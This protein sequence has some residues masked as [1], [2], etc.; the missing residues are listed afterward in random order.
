MSKKYFLWLA[1]FQAW[2]ATFGSLFFSEVLKF[3]PCTLCWYQRICMYPLTVI[4][5]VGLIR[6]NQEIYLYVLPLSLIGWIIS[7][8]HN[9]LFYHFIGQ[10]AFYCTIAGLCEER[11]LNW[12]G[13]IDIPLLSLTAFTIINLCLI[14]HWSWQR[15]RKN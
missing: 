12:L 14:F 15:N 2:V 7:F 8:Y 3:T 11:Y 1:C 10:K 13:F 6:K 9:L 4:L 5:T